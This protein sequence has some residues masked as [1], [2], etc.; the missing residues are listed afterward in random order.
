MTGIDWCSVTFLFSPDTLPVFMRELS[1]VLG[2][3][4]CI[5]EKR[6]RPGFKEGVVICGLVE[7]RLAPVAVL[8][9]GGDSQKGRALLEMSGASCAC[10]ADW[11]GFR[12]LIEGLPEARLTRVDVAV[13]LH[14]GEFTVDDCKGWY[15]G[16]LFAFRQRRA[17]ASA[18]AG[19]WIGG[20]EGRTLYVG[21]AKNGKSL[22]CYEKGKQLGDDESPW[23]RFEVQFGNRD[24]V[25]PF[26]IL[27][28]PEV[29]FVGAY[30]ALQKL[31]EF[32]GE[33]I[34]TI[35]KTSEI[36]IGHLLK[37]AK[38]AYGKVVD[39]MVRDGAVDPADFV[40]ALRI[41]EQPKRVK[42][43]GAFPGAQRLAKQTAFQRFAARG[44]MQ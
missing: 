33:R 2:L 14:H 6:S 41:S 22:R 21:K 44:G 31:F 37:H 13:D 5:R 15:E 43:P 7:Y 26:D 17:P 11:A 29:F 36:S 23:T 24:R 3:Q 27:T 25:L 9:W 42:L 39:M 35:S 20:R 34:A 32:A 4:L 40:E 28:K 18:L 10:V 38:L 19:D 30:P 1:R 16:G 12:D 8:A